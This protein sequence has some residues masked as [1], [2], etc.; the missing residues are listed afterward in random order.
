MRSSILPFKFFQGKLPDGLDIAI[1]RHNTSSHQGLSEFQAEIEVI[2][3]LRHKNII[4]LL[5]FC[6]QGKEKILV[7]EYMSN[8]SLA[9]VI[10]GM[11]LLIIWACIYYYSSVY[12]SENASP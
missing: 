12:L 11:F 1:K 2:P 6:V 3:N 9:A 4:S 5:G 7:Y 8:N 10:S